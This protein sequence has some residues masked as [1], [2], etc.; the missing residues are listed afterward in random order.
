MV[1]APGL[2]DPLWRPKKQT[3][4]L[5]LAHPEQ[6]CRRPLLP[7]RARVRADGTTDRADHAGA[8][9]GHRHVIGIAADIDDRVAVTISAEATYRDR[10]HPVGAH[11]TERHR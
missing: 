11:V 9:R 6:V 2:L 8:E 5:S 7:V 3:L 10:A 1:S 4:A